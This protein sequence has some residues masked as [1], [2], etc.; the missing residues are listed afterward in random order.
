MQHLQQANA[1]GQ[2]TPINE[3]PHGTPHAAG[4]RSQKAQR[5]DFRQTGEAA[6]PDLIK[7]FATLTARCALAGVTLIETTDDRERPAYVVS[8]W[9][10]TRQLA[11][12]DDVVVWLDHVTGVQS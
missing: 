3:N 4:V 9:A 10:L 5:A 6:Q 7:Q 1:A 11:S 2:T 8:R 12:L